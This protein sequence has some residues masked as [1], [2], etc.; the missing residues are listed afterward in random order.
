MGINVELVPFTYNKM[1]TLEE[2]LDVLLG[3]LGVH[4]FSNA[5]R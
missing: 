4:Y 3:R 1:N 5:E 2:D